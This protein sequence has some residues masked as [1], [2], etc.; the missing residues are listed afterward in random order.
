M[1]LI[2]EVGHR[3]HPERPLKSAQEQATALIWVGALKVR[4]DL[5]HPTGGELVDL[6]GE[7]SRGRAERQGR[8]RSDDVDE[9]VE[10]FAAHPQ[11]FTAL[12]HVVQRNPVER[13]VDALGDVLPD[14]GGDVDA[15]RR[16]ALV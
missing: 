15:R 4:D 8:R 16:A 7:L 12:H 6:Q 9:L 3:V 11:L 1:P 10:A 5:S 2:G 13:V 14:L